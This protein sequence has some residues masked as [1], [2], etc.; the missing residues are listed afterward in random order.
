VVVVAT[1]VVPPT[2][3]A[4]A[5]VPFMTFAPLVSPILAPPIRALAPSA[6]TE[7]PVTSVRPHG[8]QKQ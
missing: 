2:M 3:V 5:A 1:L 8:S 7:P 4:M 6:P